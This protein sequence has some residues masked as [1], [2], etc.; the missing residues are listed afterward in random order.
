MGKSSNA[1]PDE[2]FA[3]LYGQAV[4]QAHPALKY[5]HFEDRFLS[6]ED[7][8][9]EIEASDL[10][11]FPY[12]DV[13]NSGAAIFAL[14]VGRPIY[15]SGVKPFL[16]LREMVGAD[17]VHIYEGELEPEKLLNAL[18]AA[19]LLREREVEPDLAAF[20]WG[21]IADKH[22]EFFSKLSLLKNQ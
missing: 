10:V 20:S 12:N 2:D 18:G 19:R 3:E 4:S 1:S 13:L 14:S 22:A 8:V 9:A 11:V 5:F 21:L 16:E 6:D 15:A 7:L 17:W